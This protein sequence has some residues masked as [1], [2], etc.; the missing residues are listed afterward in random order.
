MKARHLTLSL[1]E[2]EALREA[3]GFRLAGEID[4]DT[5]AEEQRQRADLEAAE[6]KLAAEIARRR[7]RVG[8]RWVRNPHA[9]TTEVSAPSLRL[10]RT[11]VIAKYDGNSRAL[12]QW[13][14]TA[15]DED[16]TLDWT[17]TMREAQARAAAYEAQERAAILKGQ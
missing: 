4:A 8:L 3:V 12:G 9:S 14:L 1:A 5:E 6:A 10:G 2:L 15:S 16:E 13:R 11:Y 7:A 17:T